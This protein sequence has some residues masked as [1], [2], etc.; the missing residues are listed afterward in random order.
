MGALI[1]LSSHD[2]FLKTNNYFVPADSLVKLFL[3]NG[4]FDQ[5]E[6]SITRD[7]IIDAT[8][9]GPDLSFHPGIG[10]WYD[11]DNITY[12]QFKTGEAGTYIAGVSTAPKNIELDAK[13][14]NEYLEH[15]GVLDELDARKNEN[16]MGESA[17]E[18]YSK[19]V[20]C[21]LQVGD[22]SSD[23]FQQILGYPIEFILQDN[24]SEISS[25]SIMRFLLLS[26]KLPL[27]NQL[28]YYGYRKGDEEVV[29]EK[30]HDS[31]FVRTD[32][33]GYGSINLSNAG[34]WYLR[35]IQMARS[36]EEGLDYESNWA[37]ISFMIR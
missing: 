20:K 6:N 4:T 17:V 34:V 25:G 16:R 11:Q 7:R 1:A 33:Q 10:N 32:E 37:T 13:D 3:F 28:V 35:T 18:K 24:P 2:L 23:D 36:S 27:P 8:I 19:H 5:S 31:T 22:K 12:L 21:I 29:P 26:D 9:L 15:D 30:L 14:F